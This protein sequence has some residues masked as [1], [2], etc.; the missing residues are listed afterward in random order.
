MI[1]DVRFRYINIVFD[2]AW[3][4]SPKKNKEKKIKKK[5]L[6]ISCVF[7]LSVTAACFAAE[8]NPENGKLLFSDPKLAGSQND[9]A[10]TQCHPG[11]K[12]FKSISKDKD[13]KKTINV[14][15]TRT[16]AGNALGE[17]SQE[18]N[19]LKSYILSQSK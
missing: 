1:Q 3:L 18:M 19:D 4:Q 7:I 14:C 5:A 9:T 11:E 2:Y 15:I 10:C 17:D 16:L 12:P 13:L 6:F 8:G